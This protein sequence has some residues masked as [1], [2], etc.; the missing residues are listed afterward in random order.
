MIDNFTSSLKSDFI[1]ESGSSGLKPFKD[2][3]DFKT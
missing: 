1:L 2:V 3:R